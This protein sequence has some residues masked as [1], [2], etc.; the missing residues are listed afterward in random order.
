MSIHDSTV[1]YGPKSESALAYPIYSFITD[2]RLSIG[3][4]DDH[5]EAGDSQCL[6]RY[7][8]QENTLICSPTLFHLLLDG[9]QCS[10]E[11]GT[12]EWKFLS[13]RSVK[14]LFWSTRNVEADFHLE[15]LQLFLQ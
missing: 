10:R 13:E 2:A 11:V 5:R 8:H 3:Q 1:D 4:E 6:S 7:I 9:V 12:P 14:Q 15:I